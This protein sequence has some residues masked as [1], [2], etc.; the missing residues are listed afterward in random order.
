[1]MARSL[2]LVALNELARCSCHFTAVPGF[3]H[4]SVAEA[5]PDL[6]NMTFTPAS[7]STVEAG[8]PTKSTL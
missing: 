1:M 7:F 4:G 2:L 8:H 3:G 6:E 5:D